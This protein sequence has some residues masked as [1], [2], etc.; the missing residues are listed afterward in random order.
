MT[1]W[2]H[3]DLQS[4]GSDPVTEQGTSQNQDF[5]VQEMRNRKKKKGISHISFVVWIV[6]AVDYFL[7]MYSDCMTA[8]ATHQTVV[9][10]VIHI[11]HWGDLRVWAISVGLIK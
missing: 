6:T 5:F 2:C 4:W 8:A 10:I 7:C 3:T 9:T 1:P 11:N